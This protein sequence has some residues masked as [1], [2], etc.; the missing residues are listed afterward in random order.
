MT[1]EDEKLFVAKELGYEIENVPSEGR[2]GEPAHLLIKD[3][4]FAGTPL[5]KWNPQS[6]VSAKYWNWKELLE[7]LNENKARRAL[8]VQTVV[9][10]LIQENEPNDYDMDWVMLTVSPEILW[11]ALLKTLK[12]HEEPHE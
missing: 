8:F 2:F 9:T 3:H 6:R 4:T 11:K 7:K 10:L 5:D 12:Y 1:T